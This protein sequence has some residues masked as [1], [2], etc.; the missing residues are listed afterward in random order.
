MGERAAFVNLLKN[1][2]DRSN[3]CNM[4]ISA[5][6][7]A[8]ERGRYFNILR[9]ERIFEICKCGSIEDEKHLIHCTAYSDQR[10]QYETKLSNLSCNYSSFDESKKL[11]VFLNSSS[12]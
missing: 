8:I 12:T 3:I 2:S 11:H 4:R 6:N 9:E 1:R 7:L 5:H 10:V